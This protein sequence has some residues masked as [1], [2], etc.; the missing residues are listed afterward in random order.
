MSKITF[1]YGLQFKPLAQ[2]VADL[3][4]LVKLERQG[5]FTVLCRQLFENVYDEISDETGRL[6]IDEII[7][8]R[9]RMADV[10]ECLKELNRWDDPRY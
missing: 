9:H 5:N 1:V 3:E 6:P 2:R 4:R 7:D 10:A 8:L